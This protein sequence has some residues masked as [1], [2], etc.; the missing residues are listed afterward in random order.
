MKS[1]V[2]KYQNGKKR[3]LTQEKNILID[4]KI[5]KKTYQKKR[6]ALFMR[7]VY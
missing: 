3:A 4:Y 2:A 5:N 7:Q 1:Q 6:R